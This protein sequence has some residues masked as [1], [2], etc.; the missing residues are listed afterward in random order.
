M[1][2]QRND[3]PTRFTRRDVPRLAIAAGV[4]IL[5]LAAIL[6]ADIL[7]A[8][9]RSTPGSASWRLATSSRRARSTSRARS[10]PTPPGPPRVPPP[11]SSTPSPA[12]TR[13]RSPPPSSWRSRSASSASTRPSPPISPPRVARASSRPP[14]RTSPTPRAPRSSG[15]TRPGWAAV[16][17][18]PPGSS[19]RPSG[20]SCATPRSR[21]RGPAF[22]AGWPGQL[23]EAE[24]MLA[25]ELISPLVVPNSSFSLDLTNQA[26]AKAAEAVAPI[27]VTIRQGE[28][29]VRSGSPLSTTDI[30]KI[31]ALRLRETV[32]DV[33]S[34]GGWLLLA[35]LVVGMLLAW[36]WR[37]RPGP[38]APRQRPDPDR[39]AGR[40]RDPRPQGHGRPA[41]AAVLPADRRDRDAPRDPARRVGGDHRH[42]HRRGHRRAP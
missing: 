33:A 1:L 15:S 39:P 23:D 14:S 40:R 8:A 6:G 5:A 4:F 26:R 7:P 32:P 34:F 27:T 10:R 12:R 37:F 21:R 30:E 36:I 29:I 25:A 3:N 20:R 42:R 17:P 28:V 31:D 19:T 22:P 24:R 38:L 41:D 11:R 2:T 9:A 13:S 18:R 35:V 16:G